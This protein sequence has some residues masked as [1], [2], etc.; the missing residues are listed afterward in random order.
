MTNIDKAIEVIRREFED[1]SKVYDEHTISLALCNAGLLM[2]DL[3]E[4]TYTTGNAVVW[5]NDGDE[6][7]LED[8]EISVASAIRSPER[9]QR[10]VLAMLAAA[11]YVER[12]QA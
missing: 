12:N 9:S 4:P 7:F 8:G 6:V 1:D 3:P 10:L 5:K 11:N 2:P